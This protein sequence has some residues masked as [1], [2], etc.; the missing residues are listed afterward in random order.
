MQDQPPNIPTPPQDLQNKGKSKRKSVLTTIVTIVVIVFVTV[1]TRV[2]INTQ[3]NKEKATPE[4]LLK[5]EEITPYVS[6]EHGFTV[7]F[8]GFPSTEHST[9]D[10]EGVSVPYTQYVKELNNGNTAYMVQVAKYPKSEIDITGQE[11]GSLDGAL[12]GMVQN[13]GATIVSSSNNDTFINYPSAEAHL[14]YTED[15]KTYDVYVRNFIKDN[16]LYTI[17]TTGESRSAFDT[18]ANSLT[19]Q[20]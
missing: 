4:S 16:S 19:F 14:T 10:I 12:N 20:E 7:D 8:P 5:S 9:L 1:G 6:S 2:I 3:I 15:G 11:R 13:I 17:A 18:F